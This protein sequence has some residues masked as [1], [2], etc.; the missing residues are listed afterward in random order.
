MKN[1]LL[2][3]CLAGL[4]ALV[5]VLGITPLN[6]IAAEN[7]KVVK[8]NILLTDDL[9][10]NFYLS[11]P[12]P[13][14]TQV[15]ITVGDDKPVS[16]S[17]SALS[18]S[19]DGYYIASANVAAAQ[20][21]DTILVSVTTGGTETV[22]NTYTVAQYA[23]TVLSDSTMR[24]YHNLVKH[25]LNYGAKAQLYFDH[26]SNALAN[27]GYE[28]NQTNGVPTEVNEIGNTGSVSGISFYGASL[29]FQDKIAVRYYFRAPNG[30][31][32][33][34]FRVGDKAYSAIE[35]D[36]LYYVQVEGI[37]PQQY[38]ED[39]VLTVSDGTASQSITYSPMHYITR[40]YN[41]EESSDTLKALLDALYGYYKAACDVAAVTVTPEELGYSKITMQDLGIADGTYSDNAVRT[42]EVSGGLN[43]KYLDVD[44]SFGGAVDATSGIKFANTA[45][46]S[47]DGI[48]IGL[49]DGDRLSVVYTATNM[50]IFTLTADE[51]YVDTFTDTFNLKF[52]AT[53]ENSTAAGYKNIT[54]SL[55]INGWLVKKDVALVGVSAIGNFAGL[56]TW[57]GASVTIGA[58]AEEIPPEE[59]EP[60]ATEP[61]NPTPED[62]GYT[63]ITLKNDLSIAD[64]TYTGNAVVTS[65]YVNGLNNA[66]LDVDVSFGS[67]VD[68][69]SGIK[70]ANTSATSWDGLRI[71]L[72]DSNHLKVS[73]TATNYEIFTL[74]AEE[75]GL[76]SFTETFNL[77]FATKI[78]DSVTAGCKDVTITM[79]INDEIVK[80]DVLVG[81][82]SAIGNFAGLLTWNGA[83]VTVNSPV[84]IITPESLG[85]TRITLKDDF[86]IADGRYTGNAVVTSQYAKGLN[87]TYLDVDVSFGGTVDASSGI[88]FANTAATSWDGIKIGLVDG[89]KLTVNYTATNFEVFT[90]SAEEAGVGSFTET[91]NLKFATKITD[92]VSAGCKDVTITLWI[93]D[94]LIKKDVLVGGLSAIGNYA[95]LLTWNG[96]AVTVGTPL[97]ITLDLRVPDYMNPPTQMGGETWSGNY[98]TS[99]DEQG[100]TVVISASDEDDHYKTT[101]DYSA[102]GLD[103]VMDL[104]VDRELKILQITDTQIIDAAQCRT[105]DRLGASQ[106]AAWAT[107]NM[108]NN[109]LRYIVKAVNDTKPDLILLTGD[110]IYGEFDDNGACLMAL[111]N[112]MDSLGIPWAPV[113]GNHENESVM[114]VAWQCRQLENS[115][116]CLFKRRNEIGGNGNYSIG[117][118]KN[119]QLERVIYMMD[120]NG[121][122]RSSNVN[123]NTVK[124]TVGFTDAQKQWYRAAGLQINQVAGKTVPS[125]LGYHIPT[126][127]VLLAAQNAGYQ[128]GADS[129]N[130]KYTIGVDNVAQPGDSGCKGDLF[131]GIHQSEGLLAIMKEIGTDGAFFGHA[132]LNSTSVLYEG[133][134]WTF[135]LKTGTYDKSPTIVGGTLITLSSNSN[136]FTVEQTQTTAANIA[137]QYPNRTYTPPVVVRNDPTPEEFGYSK[138]TL[139]GLGIKDGTYSTNAVTTKQYAKGLNDVYLD[140]DVTL[141]YKADGTA[142]AS[143]GIKFANTAPTS[144]DGIK[145][146]LVDGDQLTV[147]FTTT[148]FTA[149][150]LTPAEA[151]VES[152]LEPFNLKLATKVSASETAGRT[153]VTVSMWINNRMVIDHLLVGGMTG[154]GNYVGLLTWNGAA[155]TV[156]TPTIVAEMKAENAPSLSFDIMGGEDVM[157]IAGYYGPYLSSYSHNG[158]MQPAMINDKYYA[159]FREAGLNLIC[160][161]TTDFE[162]APASVK[163]MLALGDYYGIG[164]FVTDS[165]VRSGNYPL[166]EVATR[167]KNYSGYSSF[168]GVHVVDEPYLKDVIGDGTH[169]MADYATAFAQLKELGIAAGSNLLPRWVFYSDA[170][171]ETYLNEFLKTCPTPYLSF[172]YYVFDKKMNV[173]D[174]FYN[175]SAFREK[176]AEA[177]IPLWVFIQAGSQWNNTMGTVTSQTPYYPDEGQFDWNINTS[178]AYGAKGIQYFPLIQPYW[179]AW[180]ENDTLD[181]ERNGM[182]G[183]WGEKNQ[184][185]YYAKDMKDHIGAVDEVL[186]NSVNKGVLLSGTQAKTDN[187]LSSCVISGTS[188]RELADISGDALVGCFNYQGKT[189]LYV[190]NYDMENAQYL[191]L[192]FRDSYDFRVVQNGNET[193]TSG[194]ALTLSMNAGEGVLIV[195]E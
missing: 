1:K 115:P 8:W 121:C 171:F 13:Q 123:G 18:K 154:I 73:Y 30:A 15:T 11:I 155:V 55:W 188:W 77:K 194:S 139:S 4:L 85:Y 110:I 91:F 95:G 185:F 179:F 176:A 187:Q 51:A 40:M 49:A 96:A 159:M 32:N 113:F 26:N 137:L 70:F 135:G 133:I 38:A 127:E 126:Q 191:H 42:A 136:A 183:A 182:I 29:L 189:A 180:A 141:S 108:Y 6:P 146:G 64:G 65:E 88:K 5:M 9:Q 142:D 93:N 24:P 94:Q 10:P 80:R 71:G 128:S 3:R 2:S 60:E 46:T 173:K 63:K 72:T 90:I 117:I 144:W 59:T 167:I 195:F 101:A 161:S 193:Q 53:I 122:A 21:T 178:L 129:A 152:F 140:V 163:E 150:T 190:V 181:L 92:S 114:G 132:H 120:S 169:D 160:F 104:N 158:E 131:E 184:W 58:P 125:F 39:V 50:E 52:A 138:I 79:W 16:Y 162:S 106:K 34:T 86:G 151:G 175:L 66:Y 31:A 84:S 166:V 48:K 78:V 7:A 186:M 100:S 153:D 116:Y 61:V 27:S 82:L 98:I 57:S 118:A 67:V 25:M 47:W 20:M 12:S 35:K 102:Y 75:V 41:R 130:I 174:Y 143:T 172:D 99:V 22:C 68:G 83:S 36:G 43:G 62:L 37:H 111:I 156:G 97:D 112:C 28:L 23:D 56:L 74:T 69:S 33:Y 17:A 103:Y 165:A 148:N 124:K 54:V 19:E 119:G 134:R 44:V 164:H 89:D 107:E 177:G 147:N 170:D 45:A 168:C 145:I 157:P 149:F 87:N 192:T 81:G 76:G 14:N 105:E 109:L